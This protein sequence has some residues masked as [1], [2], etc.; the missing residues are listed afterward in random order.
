MARR[1]SEIFSGTLEVPE[2]KDHLTDNIGHQIHKLHNFHRFF[3]NVL[4]VTVEHVTKLDMTVKNLLDGTVSA[5]VWFEPRANEFFS[6]PFVF[7]LLRRYIS[8]SLIELPILLTRLD[9]REDVLIIQ[10]YLVDA[11]VPFL[12]GKRTMED[13]SFQIDG[14]DKISEIISKLMDLECN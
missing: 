5:R 7:G 13:W 4:V 9:G 1:N 3:L 6:M 12:C 14:R 8:K 10:T 2:L 11:E